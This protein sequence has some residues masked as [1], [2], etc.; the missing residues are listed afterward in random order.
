[1]VGSV[2][3]PDNVQLHVNVP[4]HGSITPMYKSNISKK[5]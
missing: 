1:M 5:T 4:V 2:A 3:D